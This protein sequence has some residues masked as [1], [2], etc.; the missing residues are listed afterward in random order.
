MT[1]GDVIVG[2]LAIIGATFILLAGIGVV[3][4]P[5]L[6]ARMHAATKA[7]TIGIAL[8]GTAGA[9]A[10]DGGATKIILATA[11]IFVTAPSAAHFIG[12]AAYRAEGTTV[13]LDGPDDLHELMRSEEDA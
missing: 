10:I 6:Y 13:H 5:D 7:S 2:V 12:R 4:F 11:I 1:M 9:I 8:V 3:R